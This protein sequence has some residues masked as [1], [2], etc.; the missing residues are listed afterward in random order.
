MLETVL[1]I[2]FIAAV[3]IISLI[4]WFEVALRHLQGRIAL[5]D[6][7]YYLKQAQSAA[8][9]A[10]AEPDPT[11]ARATHAMALD[12]YDEADKARAEETRPEAG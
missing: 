11:K 7:D 3:A 4:V 1:V 8:Q 10:L 12:Y 6:P 9:L 5:P 2:I